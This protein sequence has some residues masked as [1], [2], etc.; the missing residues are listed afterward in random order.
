LIE[1]SIKQAIQSILEAIGEDLNRPGLRETPQRVAKM[2]EELF[3]GMGQDPREVLST[4]FEENHQEVVVLR[5]IPFYSMC[6]HHLLPFFGV[7]HIGYIP[8]GWIVGASKLVRA[9][10]V[11]AHR[12]QIQERLTGQM[13]DAVYDAVHADGVVVVVSAEHLC[14][15]MRGVHKPGTHIVTVATRGSFPKQSLDRSELLALLQ[16][17]CA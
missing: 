12:P 13:A 7:A 11:V 16:G 6:E 4:G 14:M 15:S 3:S 8:K 1:G 17:R 2:Y 10:E 9:L 5:D